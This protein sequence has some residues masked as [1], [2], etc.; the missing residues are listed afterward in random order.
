MPYRKR[1]EADGRRRSAANAVRNHLHPN[2]TPD[3]ET[4]IGNWTDDDFLRAMQQGIGK[5][6]EHLYP[7]FPYNSYTLLSRDDVLAVK[8]YLWRGRCTISYGN[9][10]ELSL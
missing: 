5:N 4:G 6:G 8:A 7:A 9:G 1:V 2:I 3:K 10:T